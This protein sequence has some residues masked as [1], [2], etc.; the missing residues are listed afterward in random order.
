MN[1]DIIFLQET[2]V[3]SD[4]LYTLNFVDENYNSIGVP[5][6]YSESAFR[7]LSGRPMGG[8]AVLWR[9]N[10]NF[11]IEISH[12]E[13]DYMVINIMFN[14]LKFISVNVYIRSY[15]GD[16]VTLMT[17]YFKMIGMPIHLTV[18]LEHIC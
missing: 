8:L 7:A 3:T 10:C 2:F 16:P 12:C 14:E 1:I 4:K 6:A 9:K 18:L 15:L 11:K 17:F 5:A 13:N